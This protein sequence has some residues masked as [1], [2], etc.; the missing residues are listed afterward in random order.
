VVVPSILVDSL[1]LDTSEE[2]NRR[3]KSSYVLGGGIVGFGPLKRQGCQRKSNP[4]AFD[5]D[6]MYRFDGGSSSPV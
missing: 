5:H 3:N 1:W 6:E 4:S 2:N